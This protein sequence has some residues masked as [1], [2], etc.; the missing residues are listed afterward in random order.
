MRRL[1]LSNKKVRGI[2]RRLRVLKSWAASL[3]DQFPFGL[4]ASVRYYNF[5]IPV[6]MSLV[7]GSKAKHGVQAACAQELINACESLI[8]ARPNS[9]GWSRIVAM[10][11]LPDLFSSEVCIYTVPEYFKSHIEPQKNGNISLILNSNRSLAKEWELRLP[12]GFAER[13][14]AIK[15]YDPDEPDDRYLSDH[16]YFGELYE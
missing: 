1:S 2:S 5:K 9:F 10:I 13:G 16:W 14:L 15:D 6:L 8:K 11:A 4:K 12:P 3:G 7:E